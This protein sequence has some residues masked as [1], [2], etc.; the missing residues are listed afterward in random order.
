MAKV[1]NLKRINKEDFPVEDHEFVG[2]L[3][4]ILNP[5]FEQIVTAFNKNIDFDNLN[6]EF[7]FFETEV[8]DKG[9]PKKDREIK[10]LLRS[11]PRGIMCVSANNLT[12]NT[13]VTGAP[14]ISYTINNNVIS[15][16]NITGL[17]ANKR[18]RLSL[19]IIG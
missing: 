18:F 4:F 16:Q 11:R 19:I 6:Q 17:P 5:F 10:T 3:A 7:I 12:D 9:K 1:T 15:I 2:K 14:F 13:P 8:D